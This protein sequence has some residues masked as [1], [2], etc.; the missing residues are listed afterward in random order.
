MATGKDLVDV[1]TFSA[2]V[3]VPKSGEDVSAATVEVPFQSL[4]NRTAYLHGETTRLA[5]EGN[6]FRGSGGVRAFPFVASD[7]SSSGQWDRDFT[8]GCWTQ[9]DVSG[10]NRSIIAHIHLP[11]GT[12]ITRIDVWISPSGHSAAPAVLPSWYFYKTTNAGPTL[13]TSKADTSTWPLYDSAHAISK[14][15]VSILFNDE[16]GAYTL[17]LNGEAGANALDNAL[18]VYY[19]QMY[20]TPIA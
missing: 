4:A 7:A 17:E 15:P 13:L 1:A 9:I 6:A 19:I 10:I 16:D 8:P 18:V 3:H 14:N 11:K 5:A 20:I 12:T 2:V